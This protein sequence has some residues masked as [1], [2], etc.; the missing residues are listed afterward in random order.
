M[1]MG[2]AQSSVA[3]WP[4]HCARHAR[5]GGPNLFVCWR[6]RLSALEEAP[7][8]APFGGGLVGRVVAPDLV[9]PELAR[10]VEVRR[11]VLGDEAELAQRRRRMPRELEHARVVVAHLDVVLLLVHRALEHLERL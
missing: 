2:R 6:P 9:Q 4:R 3:A 11:I 8:E 1:G 10:G 5:T 7:E